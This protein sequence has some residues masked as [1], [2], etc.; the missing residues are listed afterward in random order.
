[1]KKKSDISR[2]YNI[3]AY[4]SIPIKSDPKFTL[5]PSDRIESDIEIQRI[6][7]QPI[8]VLHKHGREAIENESSVY[9]CMRESLGPLFFLLL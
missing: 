4:H 7:R 3:Y 5:P 1:M 9:M 8:R 6:D 2:I